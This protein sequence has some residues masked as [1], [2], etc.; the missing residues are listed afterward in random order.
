[1]GQP[2]R[3]PK[4][5]ALKSLQGN[6]G[7]R[8]L[9]NNEPEF[10]KYELDAK[11][12][13]K[14]PVYLDSLAKKEWKRIAPILHKVGLLTKADE[15]ALAAYCANFSRWVQAEKLVKEAG[16][17][18]ES[19]KGNVIQRPEVGIANTAMKLMVTFCKEFGLTPSSRTS[20]SMEQAEKMESPFVSFLKGGQVG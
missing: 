7:K 8:P 3:K 17:T 9:N 12:T 6:P 10:E 13:I 20:L 5:T 2:G 19:D 18:Y 4:P 16:L 11:G 15:A 1:M 14:P